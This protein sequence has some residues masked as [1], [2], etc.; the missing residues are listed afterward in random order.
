MGRKCSVNDCINNV[1]RNISKSFYGFPKD[2][3][4]CLM[5]VKF[6]GCK[7]LERIFFSDGPSGLCKRRICS[8]HFATESFR[9][10]QLLDRGILAGAVPVYPAHQRKEVV[11][12]FVI[13]HLYFND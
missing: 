9:N 5:W 12:E 4:T 11:G 1:S 6:C 3:E 7:D 8:D 13:F 2:S 10:A